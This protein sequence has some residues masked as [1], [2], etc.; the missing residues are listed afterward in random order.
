MC[1]LTIGKAK[2]VKAKV[3]EAKV[4]ELSAATVP[5]PQRSGRVKATIS[6]QALLELSE[7]VLVFSAH[8]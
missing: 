8:N 1:R 7:M 3:V 4:V 5:D 6:L 2:A